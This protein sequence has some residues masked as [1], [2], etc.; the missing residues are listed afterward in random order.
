VPQQFKAAEANGVP[1]AIF[2]GDDEVAGGKV[3]I[4]E[5]GLQEG[6]PEKEGILVD[7]K[8]MAR[9]VKVRL[10]RK[11]ELDEMTRQA[12]GLRVVHGIK[13]DEA[14]TGD[15][16]AAAEKAPVEAPVEAPAEEKTPA[17]TPVEEK[18][19]AEEATRVN[20]ST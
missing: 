2:L 11:R 13:G 20:P 16:A 8:D 4:K 7:L 14:E 17:E 10:Q 1:F 5:M 9:E 18:T 12:E 3:K 15:V 19:P 6:H